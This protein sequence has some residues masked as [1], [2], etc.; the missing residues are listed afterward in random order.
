MGPVDGETE[1]EEVGW[2]GPLG[3]VLAHGGEGREDVVVWALGPS[4]QVER[5][6]VGGF[7]GS[8]FMGPKE[9]VRHFCKYLR[10]V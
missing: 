10:R 2:C 3:H 1:G 5:R 7:W 9:N 6:G 8:F 4:A